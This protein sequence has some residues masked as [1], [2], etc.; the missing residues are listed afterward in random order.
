MA[1][2]KAPSEILDR[3]LERS[4]ADQFELPPLVLN[5]QE[6]TPSWIER[7]LKW[8]SDLFPKRDAA[9]GAAWLGMT[10]KLVAI[11]GVIMIVVAL[12]SILFNQYRKRV[13]AEQAKG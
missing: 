1:N 6:S 8:I 3:L 10:L 12:V 11:V 9:G 4:Q 5:A 13:R 7:L 2:P